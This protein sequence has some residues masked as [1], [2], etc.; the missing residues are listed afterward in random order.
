MSDE[1]QP[2]PAAPTPPV[3]EVVML[4]GGPKH[5]LITR[6]NVEHDELV[7]DLGNKQSATYKRRPDT[8]GSVGGA[9]FDWV[10]PAK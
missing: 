2:S 4:Q 6:A 3:T 9:P 7:L 5:G 10:V 8:C 1:V